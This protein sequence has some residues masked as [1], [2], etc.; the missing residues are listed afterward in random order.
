MISPLTGFRVWWRYT[1]WRSLF[2]NLREI[3]L[4][5]IAQY[6]CVRKN[7][8]ASLGNSIVI[9]LRAVQRK[10]VSYATVTSKVF[11]VAN[12]R[13]YTVIK[14]YFRVI[15][16]YIHTFGKEKHWS[17]KR[18]AETDVFRKTHFTVDSDTNQGPRP[19]RK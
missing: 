19:D 10:A 13:I 9:V 8:S 7:V 5:F 15:V 3:I 4:F 17:A 12:L 1:V 2:R 6:R 16:S 11:P 18:H 14:W